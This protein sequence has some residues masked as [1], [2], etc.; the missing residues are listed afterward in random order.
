MHPD[1]G[2]LRLTLAVLAVSTLQ[3]CSAHLFHRH[4]N[5][6]ELYERS[7]QAHGPQQNPVIV[8]PG[9]TGSRLVDSLS[10]RTVWGAFSGNYAKPNRPDGARLIALPMR[11]GVPLEELRDG[12]K[13]NGVLE[14]IKVS[15]AGLPLHLK[16]YFQ[17]LST[18]GAGGYRDE[19]LAEADQVDWGDYHFTCFQFDY[20]WRRDN[21]ESARRLH[22]F[23]Q[24]KRAYVRRE[25]LSQYGVDP[26]ELKFDIVAHSMG[27]L[28]LRYYLR[29]GAA[30]LPAEGPLPELTWA[31]AANVERAVLV[32][33]PNAGSLEALT[34]LVEGQDY[35]P[36][37]ARYPPAVLGT[38]PAAYQMLPR[39]RHRPL[40]WSGGAEA[41]ADLF[42]VELWQTLQWGLASPTQEEVLAW[43]LPDVPDAAERREIALDHL[44]KSLARAHRFVEAIDRP[45]R[46][47]EGLQLFLL[48]GDSVPTARTVEVTRDTGRLRVLKRAPGDGSVLRSSALMDERETG[49]W[50]PGLDSP[51]VWDEVMFLF[52][53]HL[54][55]T[56]DP[57]FTDNLLYWLLEDPR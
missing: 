1:R 11:P 4:P 2:R 42:D 47:P 37:L 31:G 6:G 30:E 3:G 49:D 41:T 44:R 43:L 8:I 57:V 40:A 34:Q 13:P 26:V 48:A 19:S 14:R 16:A 55:L 24:E 29:Y 15:F 7:A 18:L 23:I 52:K 25:I 45:A 17:I 28:L 10:G 53:G 36:F 22:E 50:T 38:F 46:P 21:V 54:G 27:G 56:K 51:V 39:A 9:L 5:L 20:D 33:P 35:G 12:V 32:A